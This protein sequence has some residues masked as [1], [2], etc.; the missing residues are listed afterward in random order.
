[1]NTKDVLKKLKKDLIESEFIEKKDHIYIQKFFKSHKNISNVIELIQNQNFNSIHI[2][3]TFEPLLQILSNNNL[4][5][6]PIKYFYNYTLLQSFPNVIENNIEKKYNKLTKTYLTILRTFIDLE[7]NHSYDTWE[8][9]YAIKF[10]SNKEISNLENPEEYLRF[11]EYFR[12]DYVYEMMKLNQEYIGYST[13]KH[14][15]GVH[16]LALNIARQLKKAGIKVDLGRVSGAA[17]GHDIGK[18]GCKKNEQNR[19]AYYHYYYTGQWFKK[20][21]ITYIRNVAINHSTWDLELENLSLESLILIYA[22]FRVKNKK[23]K[24]NNRKMNFYTLKEA[25]EVIL[26][27]LDNVDKQKE[28]RYK[29]VYQK[30]YDFQS[31][32]L[33]IGINIKP[34]DSYN[35]SEFNT[36]QWEYPIM[37]G[38]QVLNNTIYLSIEHN[39]ELMYR[40][41]NETSL[42]NLL[43]KVRNTRNSTMLRGY[44]EIFNEYSTYL[45][46]KQKIIVIDFLFSN[47]MSKEED[48]REMCSVLIGKL[49]ASYD[50]KLRKELPKSVLKKEFKVNSLSLFEKYIKMFLSPPNKILEK[51]KELISFS[52]RGM[53]KGYF[54]LIDENKFSESVDI[55]LSFFNK[56]NLSDK[57]E[58]YLLKLTRILKYKKF[59]DEQNDLIIAFII[60]L[61]ESDDTKLKL[62]A[63]NSFYEVYP[64]IKQK[65]LIKYNL[66]EKLQKNIYSKK[67]P[68]E[69]YAWFKLAEVLKCDEEIIDSY[70][71]ICLDDLKYTSDIFLSNLKTA[72]YDISKRFQIELLIR[73]TILYDYSNIFYTA[74]HLCNLLKVS[75]LESVR[76]TAGKSLIE[77]FPHLSFEQKNDIVIELIR[78]LEMESYEFTKYI[79]E[80]LGKLLIHLKPVEF[81]EIIDHFHDELS[82]KQA[83]VIALFQKTI[84]VALQDFSEYKAIYSI[85]DDEYKEKLKRLLGII[86][87]AFSYDDCFIQQIALSVIGIDIFKSDQLSLDEKKEIFDIIIKKFLTLLDEN[88]EIN[89]LIFVN[90]SSALKQLYNFIAEYRFEKGEM[91]LPVLSN[92]AFFPGAFD[93]FSKS[94]KQIAKKIQKMGFEVY[95]AIDEFSWS[96]KTQPNLIRREIVQRSITKEFNIHILPKEISINIANDKDMRYLQNK[97]DRQKVYLVVG[98][99]VILNASAYKDFN[100]LIM[101]FPHVIF[102]RHKERKENVIKKFNKI[103]NNL[104]NESKIFELDKEFEFISSTQIRNYV[105]DNKDISDLID[106]I[107]QNYI[108]DKGLYQREPEYKNTIT[109]KSLQI[110][111]YENPN[112]DLLKEISKLDK[113]KRLFSVLKRLS[114]K[115]NFRV[116]VLKNISKDSEIIGFCAFHWLRSLNVNNEFE[117]K[118]MM[119]YVI[120]N[121]IGR[122]LVIDTII[123]NKLSEYNNILEMVLSETLSFSIAKDY[124]YGVYYDRFRK[125]SNKKI[126]NLLKTHGFLKIKGDIDKI[127]YAT[128]MSAPLVLNLDLKS[129]FKDEFKKNFKMKQVFKKTRYRL[130]K[131]ITKLYPGN[132]LLNYNRTM[133]YENLIKEVCKVNNVDTEITEDSNRG[134]SICVPFGAIFK[135][136]ILPNTITKTL[137]TEK[138]FNKDLSYHE[139]KSSPYYMDLENQIKM[140]KSFDKPVILV[141]GLLNK[142]YRIKV[143]EPLLEKYDIEVKKMIVG[144]LSA[145]GKSIISNNSFDVSSAYFVP[146]IK[147]WFYESRLYPFIGGD[148]VWRETKPFKKF[149]NSVN[150]IYPYTNP[151]YIKGAKKEDIMN[152]SE[153]ALKNALDIMKVAEN[154][155]Q[156]SRNRALTLERLGEVIIDPRLPDHGKN[157]HYDLH[158]NPSQYILEEINRLERLK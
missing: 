77:I 116:L 72:T 16:F 71:Q 56:N 8:S 78:A 125:E 15:S 66:K 97:F 19:V 91:K 98:S 4:P 14:V 23:D 96:K 60:N 32:L 147:V 145:N 74:Q 20:R 7:I 84:G 22:D 76:N 120:K 17:A 121:S 6:K 151:K 89:D 103:T 108:Y 117:N 130:Q 94:H 153:V 158:I 149:I 69:N 48:I 128:D 85:D 138:Y 79:P 57:H 42:N 11:I 87:S 33:N 114:R 109:T 83:K 122:I 27:K 50:E 127:A 90:N 68:A 21:D 135:R 99:D 141:D 70:R 28:Q 134:E 110:E 106:P 59:S 54:E 9:K 37:S 152:L 102:K 112:Y 150:M 5:D 62:R 137:H 104:P 34:D 105:D 140:I 155:Y 2:F 126:S 65:K 143:L 131:A 64:Y 146:N 67:N 44:I 13:L 30:L 136:W 111:V 82:K 12:K 88:N 55:L 38:D 41:R 115:L 123:E 139:I 132:L 63:F 118:E 142:G 100:S 49:I 157:I 53:V 124:S 73:N 148:G 47:L 45:T 43:E 3:E 119:E 31:F 129:M 61:M 80:Y 51:H 58:F 26:N 101:K 156:I 46:Q 1:M 10:L 25:F 107:A 36:D 81:D 144:I 113:S 95:L 93:P 86:M 35:T 133:L 24:N 39:I 40:L 92:V 52:L 75:A 29:R 18:Y 154:E